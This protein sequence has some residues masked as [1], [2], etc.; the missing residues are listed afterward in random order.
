MATLL[1]CCH[2]L[3]P[4]YSGILHDNKFD[5][6]HSELAQTASQ[7]FTKMSFVWKYIRSVNSH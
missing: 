7:S 4:V 3:Q 1:I 5:F 2:N 6:T